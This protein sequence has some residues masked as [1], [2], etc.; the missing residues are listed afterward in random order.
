MLPRFEEN[1]AAEK[2]HPSAVK[3]VLAFVPACA[4]IA[5]LT[6][7]LLNGQAATAAA[8]ESTGAPGRQEAASGKN[9]EFGERITAA[10]AEVDQLASDLQTLREEHRS[11]VSTYAARK[12]ELAVLIERDDTAVSQLAARIEQ[13]RSNQSTIKESSEKMMPQFIETAERLK[14]HISASIP[15]S[16]KERLEGVDALVSQVKGGELNVFKGFSR[17]WAL[18]EDE[19]RISNELSAS[20]QTVV[21][22]GKEV[23]ADVARLGSVLLYYSTTDGRY[24]Y[25]T[26]KQPGTWEYRPVENRVQVRLVSHLF[27]SLK[28]QI[29]V[30]LFEI[31][32]DLKTNR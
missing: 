26:E 28:K 21:I 11:Q 27:E 9:A 5:M 3:A 1:N 20:K 29:R 22:D 4:A 14:S 24:G 18:V 13:V 2:F 31:P 15:F 6:L 25:A 10:R 30:G 17:L 19:F 23:L 32:A 8:D 12:A 7:S 16:R